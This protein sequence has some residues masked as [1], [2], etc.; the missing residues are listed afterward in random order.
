MALIANTI[1]GIHEMKITDYLLLKAT[2]IIT[3]ITVA[4]TDITTLLPGH[5]PRAAD[6]LPAV[7]IDQTA[8]YDCRGHRS[9]EISIPSEFKSL[10]LFVKEPNGRLIRSYT[11]SR[12]SIN[13]FVETQPGTRIT[14]TAK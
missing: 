12:D 1:D 10:E 4:L 8:T 2:V 14:V 5:S 7:E 3:I 9:V 11:L 13:R 6:P